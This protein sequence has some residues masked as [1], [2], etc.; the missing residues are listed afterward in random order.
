MTPATIKY[1]ANLLKNLSIATEK[2]Y[3]KKPTIIKIEATIINTEP[4][5]CIL[6]LGLKLPN[7]KF[8][9]PDNKI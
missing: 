6:I 1:I 7:D 2:F 9:K 5:F 3:I 4:I 8:I